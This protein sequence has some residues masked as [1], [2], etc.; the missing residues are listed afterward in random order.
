M[1]ADFDHD[2]EFDF[3]IGATLLALGLLCLAANFGIVDFGWLDPSFL[4][5]AA[6]HFF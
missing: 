2:P 5:P 6:R 3:V 4:A 1:R